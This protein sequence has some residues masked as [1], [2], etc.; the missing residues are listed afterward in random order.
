MRTLAVLLLLAARAFAAPFLICDPYAVNTEAG[1][2][3]GTFIINGLTM[4]AITSPALINS[5]GTQSLHYDLG[6]APLTNGTKYTIS[7]QA[8]NGYG[9]VSDPS[10]LVFTKGVPAP[11]GNLRIS[12][13]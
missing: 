12:P 13:I 9:G 3:V 2:N 6:T 10:S 8:V 11:P 4:N 7:V 5:D 1:L